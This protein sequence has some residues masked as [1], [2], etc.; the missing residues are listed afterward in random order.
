MA[1]DVLLEVTWRVLQV[2]FATSYVV[3]PAICMDSY[4]FMLLL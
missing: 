1:G 4:V 2:F 3:L